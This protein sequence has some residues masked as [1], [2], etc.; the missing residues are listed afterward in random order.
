MISELQIKITDILT[1]NFIRNSPHISKKLV[2]AYLKL[3][4]INRHFIELVDFYLYHPQKN[5]SH[6]Q[7]QNRR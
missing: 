2:K 1:A 6:W 7:K 3:V 4:L 5:I